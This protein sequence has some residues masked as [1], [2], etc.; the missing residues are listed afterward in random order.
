MIRTWLCLWCLGMVGVGAGGQSA[1][2]WLNFPLTLH[3]A[4]THWSV[5]WRLLESLCLNEQQIV[6]LCFSR[7]GGSAQ[8][9]LLCLLWGVGNAVKTACAACRERKGQRS[10]SASHNPQLSS[11]QTPDK[12]IIQHIFLE[13]EKSRSYINT[14]AQFVMYLNGIS[15]LEE[16]SPCSFQLL[17]QHVMKYHFC[18]TNKHKA[19]C[20]P[21]FIY[22]L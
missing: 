3:G 9:L 13:R 22:S 7:K 4:G 1:G 14:N 18:K 20:F 16:P 21:A 17:R 12:E 8:G 10:L 15:P 2:K 11:P 5:V 6:W 19:E